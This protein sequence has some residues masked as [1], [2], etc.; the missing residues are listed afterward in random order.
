M[1]IEYWINGRKVPASRVGDQLQG[2]L[3]KEAAQQVTAKVGSLR[4]SQ[5]GQHPK[6]I[7]KSSSSREVRLS[8]E[9]CCDA[10]TETVR[11]VVQ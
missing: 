1:D 4:C 11:R 2:E 5:H 9:G 6:V 3:L 7:V 10:L 8:V